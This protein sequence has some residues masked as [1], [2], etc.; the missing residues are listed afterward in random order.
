M[1]ADFAAT[2]ATHPILE[3]DSIVDYAPRSQFEAFHVRTGRFACI[4]T[5]RRAGKTVACIHDLQHA[6]VSNRKVRPRYAY[7]SPFLNQSK[8][9]ACSRPRWWRVLRKADGARRRG[10]AHRGRAVRSGGA[11]VDELG[12]RHSRCDRHLEHGVV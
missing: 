7:L 3:P 11:G 2:N 8:T 4:V 9:M 12:S 6:A 10:G 1:S 5:H